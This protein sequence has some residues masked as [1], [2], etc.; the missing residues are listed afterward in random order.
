[1]SGWDVAEV[2]YSTDRIAERA[3]DGRRARTRAQFFSFLHE[4]Q[5]DGA[6][7]YDERLRNNYQAGVF[8][9]ARCCD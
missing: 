5:E 6:A 9:G 2:S 1:M 7:V 4:Y 3:P 8:C